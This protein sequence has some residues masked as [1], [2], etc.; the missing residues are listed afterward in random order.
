MANLKFK[1][2]V[3]ILTIYKQ[4]KEKMA[5]TYYKHK[6]GGI[7]QFVSEMVIDNE[8]QTIYKHIYPFEQ[9]LF[10]KHSDEFKANFKQITE[11]QLNEELSKQQEDFQKEITF[12]KL[13]NKSISSANHTS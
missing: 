10:Q 6:Y 1:S 4:S 12:N 3:R 5:N 9:K 13:S 2:F 11:S 8:P 7:Y